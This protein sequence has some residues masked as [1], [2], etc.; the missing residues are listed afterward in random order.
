VY[1]LELPKS[2]YF[3]DYSAMSLLATEQ[4]QT[5]KLAISSQESSAVW[6]GLLTVS[7]D[8]TA[9]DWSFSNGFLFIIYFFF[10]Y[11]LLFLILYDRSNL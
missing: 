6:I 3:V 8:R 5:Y 7:D 11:A 2:V 9:S 1:I 4:E 10:F